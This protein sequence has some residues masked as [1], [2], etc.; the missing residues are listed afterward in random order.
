M[1][2]DENEKYIEGLFSR[3]GLRFPA[4]TRFDAHT[5]LLERSKIGP[6]FASGFSCSVKP[7]SHSVST[8]CM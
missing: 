4:D 1:P 3:E 5:A 6:D 8:G 7:G 2:R